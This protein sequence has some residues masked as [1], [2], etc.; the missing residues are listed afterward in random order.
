M[1][2]EDINQY[3]DAMIK[4]IKEHPDIELYSVL[5]QHPDT[6]SSKGALSESFV[7]LAIHPITPAKDIVLL[8]SYIDEI[9]AEDFRPNYTMH[10]QEEKK[11]HHIP[12]LGFSRNDNVRLPLL[13]LSK[14]YLLSTDDNAVIEE[15]YGNNIHL[16]RGSGSGTFIHKV[17]YD[18]IVF[19]DSDTA[20]QFVPEL[21]RFGEP[22]IAPIN[23]FKSSD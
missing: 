18:V 1:F 10:A 6:L 15:L 19:P 12:S 14:E 11:S 21:H 4:S 8:N 2:S 16:I 20:S 17:N 9:L 23:I 3:I 13:S 5:I 22:Y 7:Y